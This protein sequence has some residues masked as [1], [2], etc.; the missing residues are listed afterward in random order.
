MI[1]LNKFPMHEKPLA[2]STLRCMKRKDIIE[3]IR[4]IEH[5]YEAL[6]ET[7]IQSVKNAE[8]LLTERKEE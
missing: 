4:C 8:R 6:Y 7:Y 1:D 5:N 2:D 3:Y